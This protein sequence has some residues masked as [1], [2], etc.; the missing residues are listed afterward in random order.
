MRERRNITSGTMWEQ[1]FAYSRAV[2]KGD[3]VKV[4]A[5]AAVDDGEIVGPGDPYEQARYVL[6]T[7]EATLEEA[8]AAMTDIVHTRIYVT[9]FEHWEEV[10]RAHREFFADVKPANTLLE[11]DGLPMEEL[12]LEIEAEAIVD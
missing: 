11:V 9:E 6:E 12:L 2:R 3:V 1:Q 5:T 10:G 7:I 8:D 4:S